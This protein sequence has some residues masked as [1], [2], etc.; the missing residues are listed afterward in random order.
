MK[1]GILHLSD[2]HFGVIDNFADKRVLEIVSTLK[3]NCSEIQK[4]IIVV[5]GDIANTGV[6][7]EYEVATN[8]LKEIQEKSKAQI[9]GLNSVRFVVIPGNHDCY[10]PKSDTVRDALINSYQGKDD[11]DDKVIEEI[12]KSQDSFWDFYKELIGEVPNK[13]A[14]EIKI[15]ITLDKTINFCCYNSSWMS[16]RNEIVGNSIFPERYLISAKSKEITISIHHHPVNWLSPNTPKNNKRIFSQHL[17]KNSDIVLC[18]HEHEEIGEKRG[19][20]DGSSDVKYFESSAL[21]NW[22]DESSGFNIVCIDTNNM[23]GRRSSY[24]YIENSYT[25]INED[26]FLLTNNRTETIQ[27]L[28]AFKSELCKIRIPL[29]HSQKEELELSDIFI[30]PDLEPILE[31]SEDVAQYIDAE[32]ILSSDDEK[33][34]IEGEGQ[35]GKRSLLNTYFRY[36]FSQGYYPLLLEGKAIKNFDLEAIIKKNVK[37]QYTISKGRVHE[38]YLKISNDKKILLIDQID[39]SIL[40]EVSK[41]KLLAK[42]DRFFSKVIISVAEENEMHVIAE[43]EKLYKDYLH[44]KILPL[45][46]LKRNELIEKWIRIGKDELSS[47]EGEIV[48]QVKITYDNVSNLLG[49]QLIP[50]FPV[51]ILT[52]MQ[53]LDNPVTFDVAPTSYAYCYHSLIHI[54]IARQGVDKSRIGSVFNYL[55]EL[56]FE[57]FESKKE[58]LSKVDLEQFY[59]NYTSRFI[60][61][62]SF[63][64]LNEILVKSNILRE[65]HD[66]FKFGY[67]YIAYYL[68][69]KKI[70]VLMTENQDRLIIK[71]LCKD[72][73]LEKNANILIFLTHHSGNTKLIEE[74]IFS[75]MLPFESKE[76]ITLGTDDQLFSFLKGFIGDIKDE[77]IPQL[78][79][80]KANRKQTLER[81]DQSLRNRITEDSN[82]KH[83]DTENKDIL[84]FGQTFKTI[85]ILGQIV[86]NQQGNFEKEKLEDLVEAAYNVCFRSIAFVSEIIGRD[87]EGLAQLLIE[88]N[89][90]ENEKDAI[91]VKI[92]RF[93]YFLVYRICLQSLSN[94]SISVGT[95]NLDDVY[96]KVSK[97]IDSPAAKLVSFNIK[98]YYGNLSIIELEQLMKEFENNPVATHML[99]S[100]VKNYIYN[101]SLIHS[102]RQKIDQ[103]CSFQKK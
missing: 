63:E 22:K 45:G 81:K 39:E 31:D 15:P 33:L 95:S 34:L 101:N 64:K 17:N 74:I 88:K 87:K 21:Q 53:S 44:Y 5:T 25:P 66:S 36:Y 50:S 41:K 103:I 90:N 32:E 24:A 9:V 35:A 4:L 14:Y 73:H 86:K 77:V 55:T 12:L 3:V 52:I 61:E 91:I 70:S 16:Q 40:N 94:L 59:S 51:F 48:R 57:L 98:S 8:F 67:K 46:F 30:F 65:N 49:E 69:A 62:F 72:I 2:I 43:N 79:D 71:D 93:I 23:N 18:G 80:A 1:V 47:V 56:S 11:T 85:K 19:A 84:E 82:E 60:I 10:L 96:T 26:D 28:D 68:T 7:E 92:R 6:A 78:I 13:M 20:I 27:L 89:E 97:N 58:E 54:G 42:F 37:N 38:E 29:R 100:R 83:F 76:P 75:S 99:R 102:K